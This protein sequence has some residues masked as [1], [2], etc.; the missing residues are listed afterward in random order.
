MTIVQLNPPLP[1]NT[2][3]GSALGISS[4]TTGRNMISCGPFFLMPTASAGHSQIR[5]YEPRAM[6]RWVEIQFR[7]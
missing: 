1:L 7:Q 6:K 5:K 2:P 3:K 4:S